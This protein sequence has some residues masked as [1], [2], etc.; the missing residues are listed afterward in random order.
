MMLHV[1]FALVA[2]I[3]LAASLPAK[4]T[5][6]LPVAMLNVLSESDDCVLPVGFVVQNF[7]IWTPAPN[8]K[9]SI[10]IDF[11]LIDDSTGINTPCQFNE[12]SVSSGPSGLTARYACDNPVVQFIWEDNV[13]TVIEKACP[14]SSSAMGFEASG[15]VTPPLTCVPTSSN[16]TFG[17][18]SAC[19][20]SEYGIPQNYT[21]LQPSPQN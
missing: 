18:G 2:A 9:Q 4:P 12:T 17:A 20:S 11:E 6:R 13:L 21:S 10:N 1:I 19:F 3:P 16:T 14:G 8:N 5:Y 15:S 7:Q